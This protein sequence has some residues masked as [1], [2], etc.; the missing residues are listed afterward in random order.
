MRS[1][2]Q[3]DPV[4]QLGSLETAAQYSRGL[5]E[6]ETTESKPILSPFPGRSSTILSLGS[7]AC[8]HWKGH[9]GS[10]WT[11]PKEKAWTA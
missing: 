6:T 11:M 9:E 2:I 8:R 3:Q 5:S 7:N 1:D 4:E 10:G